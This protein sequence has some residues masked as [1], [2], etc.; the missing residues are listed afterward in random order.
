MALGGNPVFNSKNYREQTRA[1]G[2]TG[3]ASTTYAQPMSSQALQD[4][5]SQPSASPQDTG[6]MTYAD[7]IN[8]TLLSLGLVLIGAGIGWQMSG[9]MLVGAIVGLVLGLVN[10]FKR[11]PS[12]VLIMLYAGFE[13]LFLGGLSRF[14]ENMYPGIAVQA[15]LATF[16]VFAVTL[17]L[18]RSGKYRATPKMTRMFMIAMIG[19]GVFSLLNFVLMMTGTIDGMFG[20]RSGLLGLGIGVL[21]VLLATYALVLDFTNISDGVRQGA[22]AKM[23][24]SAAFGLTVTLIWLY[25]E[26]LRILAIL[27]GDD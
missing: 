2:A 18:Y 15:V 7:V 21:A 26:I 4:M 9:L 13:G 11:Q 6:R 3:A 27:R 14:F 23:A 12:P 24:W 8:K 16:S 25:V 1:A 5:Y 19:Y 17:V 22:P 10:S 20:M